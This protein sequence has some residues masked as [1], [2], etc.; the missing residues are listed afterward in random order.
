[1]PN[2]PY[3]KGIAFAARNVDYTLHFDNDVPLT[4]LPEVTTIFVNDVLEAVL[5]FDS[6]RTT[7]AGTPFGFS[8]TPSGSKWY[9]HF[10]NGEVRFYT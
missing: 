8:F 9:Q 4:G 3:Y 7:G 5:V 10:Q 2:S 6:A 1:V